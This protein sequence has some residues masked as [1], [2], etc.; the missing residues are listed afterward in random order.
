MNTAITG[1]ATRMTP[2]SGTFRRSAMMMPPMLMIGAEITTLSIISTTICTC[3]TSLVVRVMRDG[4][5]KR[6]TSACEKLSTRRNSAA[7]T[8]R[9]KPMATRDPQYT[10]MTAATTNS[11]VTPS[12]IA[13]VRTM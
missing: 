9:P 7:R 1:M 5:P 12:M 4:V 6:F 10:A 2:D 3:C 11:S 13:P 8:S